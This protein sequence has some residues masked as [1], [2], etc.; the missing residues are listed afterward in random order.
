M[1]EA[2]LCPKCG[3]FILSTYCYTCKEDIRS[4]K[5]NKKNEDFVNFFNDIINKGKE[6]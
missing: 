4:M 2:N 5:V 3:C 1:N 6:K